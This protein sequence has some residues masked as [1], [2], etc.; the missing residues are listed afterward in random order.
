MVQGW[1]R[2]VAAGLAATVVLAGADAPAVARSSGDVAE[3]A[4]RTAS[5]QWPDSKCRRREIVTR[6]PQAVLDA[7]HLASGLAGDALAATCSVRVVASARRW[8]GPRLCALLQHEFGH[9]ASRPHTDDPVDVM[10]EGPIP[11]TKP[12]TRAFP[13]PRARSKDWRCRTA[14]AASMAMVWTCKPRRAR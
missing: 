8:S 1:T 7:E 9:L 12:C 3:V 14:R 11:W 6:V 2:C 4:K 10:F 13:P 5:A